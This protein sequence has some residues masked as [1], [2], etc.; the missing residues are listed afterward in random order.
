VST[1][2]SGAAPLGRSRP[3]GRLAPV[4][5]SG[6]RSLTWLPQPAQN[7]A[8]K[9]AVARGIFWL[10]LSLAG[11]ARA[12]LS[13][14]AVLDGASSHEDAVIHY[15]GQRV[16]GRQEVD[17]T[18]SL[19][20]TFG[21]GRPHTLLLA[22]I[23]E[24]GYVVS[25]IT[26]EGYLRVQRL[27]ASPPHPRFD[28]FFRA[29][30]VRVTTASGRVVNGV[31]AAHSVHLQWDRSVQPRNDHPELFHIDVGA[32]SRREA[33]EAGLDLLDAV[34]L[35]KAFVRLGA[36][37]QVS[38]PWISG[39]AGAAVL[40]SLAKRLAAGPARGTVT[41]AF[42]T[43]HYSGHRGL[44]RVAQRVD[45][46]RVVW[47]RPGGNG[48]PAAAPVSNPDPAMVTELLSL[49]RKR[50]FELARGA[51]ERLQVPAF[52]KEE[53]WKHPERVA[54]LGLGVKNAGTP[55]E[56]VTIPVLEQIEALLAE[57]AGIAA[58]APDL[59]IGT[60][61]EIPEGTSTLE[62][63]LGVY[64]VSGREA[65]VRQAVEALLPPWARQR[66]Q[67]D[68]HGNLVVAVGEK[69][70]RL[71]VAHLDELGHR[72]TGFDPDGSLRTETRGGSI[73]DHS[74]W[75]DG[76]V[77]TGSR[78]LPAIFTAGEYGG[79]A[80]LDIGAG[81][82]QQAAE[83]GVRIGDT[84]ALR[85][86][87]RRLLG[88]RVNARSLDDRIG[89]AVLVDVLR[90]LRPE[91]IR[92]GAWFA[93]VVEEEVGLRGSARLAEK[94]RPQEVY[95]IDT[96]V[97]SDSPL[98]NP[99]MA[100]A[101]L[102]EGFVIRA[103]DSSGITPREAV[104]RVVELARKHGIPVQYGVTAGANDGSQFVEGGAV[105]IPLGWPLRYSHSPAEVADLADVE[106][107]RK[108]I[109]VLATQ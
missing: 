20:A 30:P 100:L 62:K 104:L 17:N 92:P 27:S 44:A 2:T 86:S 56:V 96:F 14:L 7:R 21:A 97:T 41:L 43:Q 9:Q 4:A 46:D 25:G 19:T 80:R 99:R 106:A 31:L 22:G 57:F 101:R 69:P 84:F 59:R 37:G 105:N 15:L 72:V 35:E 50:G 12:D 87:Y 78:R 16:G 53:I 13:A 60:A 55:V 6:L 10:A 94:V 107:L 18:G 26:E 11:I 76:F 66:A 75:H 93:F 89:C 102:G 64:G 91:Q 39:R 70:E 88:G 83:M 52:A 28:D 108:I 58:G 24:P 5:G 61:P 47:L 36:A 73:T 51:A 63:L 90:A 82:P 32:R 34:T 42:V 23:D 54:A 98:E 103:M 45:A 3:P 71:F 49:A 95:P 74:E 40:L 38:A 68:E 79:S 8:R 81:S 65:P 48:A 67:T 29:Q 1:V 33:R 109:H 85:K 77:M